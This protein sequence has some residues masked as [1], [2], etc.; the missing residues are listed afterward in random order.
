MA[1]IRAQSA[2]AYS[3]QDFIALRI[4]SEMRSSA[5]CSAAPQ[6]PRSMRWWTDRAARSNWG[7]L[8]KGEIKYGKERCL[9]VGGSAKA[10]HEERRTSTKKE[11]VSS[12]NLRVKRAVIEFWS[13]FFSLNNPWNA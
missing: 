9:L 7:R 5:F 10:R 3:T 1:E 6:H 2:F 4:W 8:T 12:T 11:W 13:V